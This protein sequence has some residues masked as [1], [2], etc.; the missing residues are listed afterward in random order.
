[1]AGIVLNSALIVAP[2]QVPEEE[3]AQ[4]EWLVGELGRLR[5]DGAEPILVFQHHSYF[6][7]QADEEDAYFNVPIEPRTRY[8]ELLR[9]N[10]VRVVF[11]G[12]YHRNGH[13]LFG[14]LEMVTSGPVGRPLGDNP[15]GLRVVTVDGGEIAHRY[16]GLDALP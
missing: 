8:L 13:G 5:A 16:Y 1:M 7:G 4:W 11:A 2:E 9:D 6:L 14:S 15:S 12:H 10:G 3:R